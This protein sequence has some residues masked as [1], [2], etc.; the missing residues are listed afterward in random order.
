MS[1]VNNGRSGTILRE[2]IVPFVL[3]KRKWVRASHRDVDMAQHDLPDLPS[4]ETKKS[5]FLPLRRNRGWQE[6]KIF[7]RSEQE[8][9]PYGRPDMSGFRKHGMSASDS[10]AGTQTI[11]TSE[12]FACV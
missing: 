1:E 11:S 3:F 4:A 12:V 10:D 7:G 9:S 5:L 2:I 8:A 6:E